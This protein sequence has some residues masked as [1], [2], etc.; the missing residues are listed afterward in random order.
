MRYAILYEPTSTGFSAHVPDLP[1]C[2][3]TG[4]TLEETRELLKGAIEGHLDLMRQFGYEI[5]KPTTV[6]EGLEIPV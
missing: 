4:A 3:A 5:P 2:V 6:A 1:G